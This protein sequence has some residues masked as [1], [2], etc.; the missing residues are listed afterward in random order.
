MDR[1]ESAAYMYYHD[2]VHEVSF[3]W[4]GISDFIEVSG[5][6]FVNP[7]TESIGVTGTPYDGTSAVGWLRWFESRC[8]THIRMRIIAQQMIVQPSGETT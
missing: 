5:G 7:Q 6:G 8:V 4:D 1:V 2:N 3:R